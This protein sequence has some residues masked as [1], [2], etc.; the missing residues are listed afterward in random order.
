[1][2]KHLVIF[3]V[4]VTCVS[5][6]GYVVGYTSVKGNMT[7][8][9]VGKTPTSVEVADLNGDRIPDL[10]VANGGDSSVTVLLGNGK[11]LFNEATGSPFYAGCSP[12]DV[13]IADINKDGKPDLVFANHTRKYLTILVGDGKGGFLPLQGSPFAVNVTPHTHGVVVADF[14]RD[15][16][17]DLATDSWGNN[18][19]EILFGN[20]RHGFDTPGIFITV[21]KHPYQRLRAQI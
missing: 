8:I 7:T 16:N 17:L 3:S 19:I 14:N 2:K 4:I 12:N 6:F 15:G 20:S 9:K 5:I 10:V 11:G 1:M 21:G 13:A 18:R